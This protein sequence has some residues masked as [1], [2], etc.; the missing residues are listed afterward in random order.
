[1]FSD[2]SVLLQAIL[3]FLPLVGFVSNHKAINRL[4][5]Y[6]KNW[7]IILFLLFICYLLARIILVTLFY[8][9]H[10][11]LVESENLSIQQSSGGLFVFDLLFWTTAWNIKFIG[12]EGSEQYKIVG[13]MIL[14][15]IM[16]FFGAIFIISIVR[17]SDMIWEL[18]VLF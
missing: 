2:I 9:M 7:K 5:S 18:S 12:D 15:A 6:R 10:R 1:M 11:Y 8:S 16:I 3:I 14:E 17:I 13:L 4:K